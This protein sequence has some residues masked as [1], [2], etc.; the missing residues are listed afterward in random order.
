MEWFF[1]TRTWRAM[2]GDDGGETGIGNGM[3]ERGFANVGAWILG[4]TC[5]SAWR[6]TAL[7]G[8]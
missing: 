8:R 2:R 4:N 3:A 7:Q 6:R 1:H 5:A